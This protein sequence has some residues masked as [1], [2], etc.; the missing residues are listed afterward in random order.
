MISVHALAPIF[1]S[2]TPPSYVLSRSYRWRK[3]SCAAAAGKAITGESSSFKPIVEASVANAAL[4]RVSRKEV[5]VSHGDWPPVAEVAQP[6]G[7]AGAETPS[8]FSVKMLL[9]MLW[10]S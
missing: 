7:R 3:D 2:S 1:I 4:G 9:E 5:E 10:P 8:K 6:G